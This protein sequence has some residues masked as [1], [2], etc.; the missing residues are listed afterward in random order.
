MALT[1]CIPPQVQNRGHV[2]AL[3]HMKDI[4]VGTTTR[5][6]VRGLLGTPS[7]TNNYGLETWYYISKQK[8]AIAFLKP[9][10]TDQHVTRIAFDQTGVVTQLETKTLKDSKF[11]SV[12]KEVTPTEGQQLG[13]FEQML[14]NVGRFNAAEGANRTH[15]SSNSPGG[16]R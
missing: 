2:D 4:V 7:L 12:A 1:A 5:D 14:G 11:V 3:G 8:Q 6:Q 9:E 10:I 15:P 16:R 13:L